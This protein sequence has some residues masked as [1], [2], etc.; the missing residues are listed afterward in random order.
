MVVIKLLSQNFVKTCCHHQQSIRLITYLHSGPRV[1]GI[2]RDPKSYL[3]SPKGLSYADIK[4]SE[5][6]DKVQKALEF[7]Q[8]GVDLP[9]EV[10][11]Q[12]LTHKSF[13][14]GSKPYNEKLN[15]LGSQFLKYQASIHSLKQKANLSPVSKGKIQQSLNNLNFTN[16]GTQLSK[17]LISKDATAEFIKEKH[18]DSLIF[19]KMRDV[20]KDGRFNGETAIFSS[21]LNAIGGAILIS[22]GPEKAG[23]F[24]EQVLLNGENDVSLVKIANRQFATGFEESKS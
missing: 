23:R 20:T 22:S 24:V 21:A 15:L 6:K 10:V 5:Y 13:A 17:L 18:L 14:H 12:C 7:D 8:C 16:L 1:R 2:K 3:K 4:L 11:L 9:E 19:W